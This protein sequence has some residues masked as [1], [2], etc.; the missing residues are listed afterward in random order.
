MVLRNACALAAP[1]AFALAAGAVRRTSRLC[2]ATLGG[3][4]LIAHT[5]VLLAGL[6]GHLTIRGLAVVVTA[7]LVAGIGL[8]WSRRGRHAPR[9]L[10]ESHESADI[11]VPPGALALFPP[12]AAT[13]ALVVWLRPHLM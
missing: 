5:S 8:A 4:L 2:L 10:A 1:L 3:D 13:A 11:H 12:L 9:V 6:A 7:A